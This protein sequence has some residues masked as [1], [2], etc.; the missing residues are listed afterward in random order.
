MKWQQ[1][2]V[3]L[4]ETHHTNPFVQILRKREHYVRMAKLKPFETIISFHFWLIEK[5]DFVLSLISRPN[6]EYYLQPAAYS[7]PEES[8]SGLNLP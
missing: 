3:T 1:W 4:R 2:C 5:L 6:I 7:N 8:Q